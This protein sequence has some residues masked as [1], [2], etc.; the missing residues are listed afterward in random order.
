MIH[1]Q[2][3]ELEIALRSLSTKTGYSLTVLTR[4]LLRLGLKS[5]PAAI[6]VAAIACVRPMGRPATPEVEVQ[7][8]AKQ[9]KVLSPFETPGTWEY[10]LKHG[11]KTSKINKKK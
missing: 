11:A 5:K 6:Q 8:N 4:A 3:Q 7:E 10:D 9:T 1:V 2:D